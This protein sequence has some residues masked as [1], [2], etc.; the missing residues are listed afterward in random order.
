M[1]KRNLTCIDCI[2]ENSSFM[3]FLNFAKIFWIVA[4]QCHETFE[5]RRD[6]DD[7]QVI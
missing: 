3:N 5:L 6:C 1:E 4:K 2:T 7:R